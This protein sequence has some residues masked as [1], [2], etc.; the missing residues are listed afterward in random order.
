MSRTLKFFMPMKRVPTHTAQ[1]G[2][3]AAI[4]KG[5]KAGKIVHY[6]DTELDAVHSLYTAHLAAHRPEVPFQPPIRLG[7][8]FQF[9][10]TKKGKEGYWKTTKP[11]DDNMVK[12]PKDV[13]TKLGFWP[14]DAACSSTN[15]DK[16][17]SANTGVWI[18]IEQLEQP[19]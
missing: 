19:T 5:K 17:H 8:R 3:R 16:I 9:P 14:D 12:V 13:M 15:Y 11:D 4:G 18:Y 1:Q 10:L 6:R 7:M 2:S